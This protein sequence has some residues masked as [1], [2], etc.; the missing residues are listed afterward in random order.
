[1]IELLCIWKWELLL[2]CI[3]KWEL[4]KECFLLDCMI[5][6]KNYGM[7]IREFML[8]WDDVGYMVML[9]EVVC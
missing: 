3:W 7:K 9:C 8:Y 5:V 2:E 4:K 1:M 6:I